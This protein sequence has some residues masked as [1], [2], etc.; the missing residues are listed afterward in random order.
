MRSLEDGPRRLGGGRRRRHRNGGRVRHR[1]GLRD[2]GQDGR[3]LA[4]RGLQ[5]VLAPKGDEVD[6]F[7]GFDHG[8]KGRSA[9]RTQGISCHDS[10][11]GAAVATGMPTS[12]FATDSGEPE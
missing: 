3:G 10:T 1:S 5:V 6:V 2:P 7:V 4:L 11:T 12:A 8:L 9:F